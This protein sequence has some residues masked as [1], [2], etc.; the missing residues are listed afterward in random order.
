MVL[1]DDW[2]IQRTKR[3]GTLAIEILMALRSICRDTNDVAISWASDI[4]DLLEKDAVDRVE[5]G[6][7]LAFETFTTLRDFY[8]VKI[9]E[10][11][12]CRSFSD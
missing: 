11:R 10:D 8:P 9:G 5:D 7:P 4:N 2:L 3:G 12:A 1:D 6:G